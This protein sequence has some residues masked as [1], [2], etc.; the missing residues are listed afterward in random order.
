MAF[1]RDFHQKALFDLEIE[2]V[3][4]AKFTKVQIPEITVE[5]V[6][7]WDGRSKHAFKRPGNVKYGDLTLTHGYASNTT[8]EDWWQ[9]VRKGV[10]DR[11]SVTLKMYNEEDAVVKSWNFYECWPKKWKISEF[12]GKA[13]EVVTEEL[14]LNVEFM[15]H[16]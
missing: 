2:G 15:E 5:T 4:V 3:S 16:A 14:T 8:L 7:Y 10:Q 1:D 6:E 13:N 11:K 12:D 9:N